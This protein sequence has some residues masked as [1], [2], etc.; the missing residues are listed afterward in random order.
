MANYLE[1]IAEELGIS[2]SL[3]IVMLIWS[4]V[5]KI[6]ALWKSARNKHIVWFIVLI[7]INTVGILEILYIFVFSKCCKKPSQRVKRTKKK[8]RKRRRR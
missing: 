7:L 2:V 6:V 4:A 3:V 1:L 8:Q 5:W